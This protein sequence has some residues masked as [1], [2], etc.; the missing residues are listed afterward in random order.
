MTGP[1][2]DRSPRCLRNVPIQHVP[3]QT[4][5]FPLPEGFTTY[6]IKCS[7]SH[8]VWKIEGNWFEE[9]TEFVGP[10]IATC[11]KCGST[12]RI[13]ITATDGHNGEIADGIVEEATTSATWSCPECNFH[14]DGFSPLS[15]TILNQKQSML[16]RCRTISMFSFCRMDV[17]IQAEQ[18][19]LQC[20]IAHETRQKPTVVV[21]PVNM[22][23]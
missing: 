17:C 22:T 21:N 11:Q 13:I 4:V 1:V 5:G 19:K 9:S 14:S 7:C 3:A 23:G 16:V 6:R 8:P 12:V 15:V 18:F 20:S 2:P 10:L